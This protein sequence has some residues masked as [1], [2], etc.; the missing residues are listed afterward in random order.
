LEFLLLYSNNLKVVGVGVT[1]I[2]VIRQKVDALQIREANA[3]ASR[4]KDAQH[5]P[6][7]PRMPQAIRSDPIKANTADARHGRRAGPRRPLLRNLFDQ[8]FS[9]DGLE[10]AWIY[11]ETINSP[12]ISRIATHPTTNEDTTPKD[13]TN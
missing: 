3:K 6:L 9:K 8:R 10:L 13:T 12:A 4:R 1:L 11:Q 7:G 5:K 2:G